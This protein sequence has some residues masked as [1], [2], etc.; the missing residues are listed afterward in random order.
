MGLLNFPI[1]DP[2]TG[3]IEA[4][5]VKPLTLALRDA[6]LMTTDIL[7]FKKNIYIKSDK[8]LAEPADVVR[9]ATILDDGR[10]FLNKAVRNE[11][12]KKYG[13]V[14]NLTFSTETYVMRQLYVRRSILGLFSW[15]HTIFP[16][17]RVLKVLLEA[18]VI[19]DSTSKKEK[20]PDGSVEPA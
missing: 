11:K 19:E 5:W 6:I 14:Y 1:I 7:A 17:E 9:I 20:V 18:V 2:D 4:F 10:Q 15:G 16:Y 13:S 12:G 3:V 8:V